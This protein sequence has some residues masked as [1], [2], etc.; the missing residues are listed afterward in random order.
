MSESP[1]YSLRDE[2]VKA[3][4]NNKAKRTELINERVKSESLERKL[5]DAMREK[6]LLEI[7]NKTLQVSARLDPRLCLP[8][9]CLESSLLIY[10]MMDRG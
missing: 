8:V 9:V 6:Q 1:V 4:A 5:A 2:L 3:L 7:E 10:S